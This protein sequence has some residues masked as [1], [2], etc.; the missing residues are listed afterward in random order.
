MDE[1]SLEAY[2]FAIQ[3]KKTGTVPSVLDSAEVAVE[4]DWTGKVETFNDFHV[5][6][7]VVWL[8]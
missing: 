7:G 8:Y 6:Q 4:T 2:P 1:K 5:E 3:E